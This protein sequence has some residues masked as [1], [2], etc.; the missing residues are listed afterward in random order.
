MN[1]ITSCTRNAPGNFR[2]D[3]RAHS[4]GKRI[5]L[6]PLQGHILHEMHRAYMIQ[7]PV[8]TGLVDLVGR[9]KSAGAKAQIFVGLQ[10]HG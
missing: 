7:N 5:G 9:E 1:C 4:E 8:K 6:Q 3:N 2:S 10:R